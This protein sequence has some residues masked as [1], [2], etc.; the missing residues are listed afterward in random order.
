M[1]YK[2]SNYYQKYSLFCEEATRFKTYKKKKIKIKKEEDSNFYWKQSLGDKT[3][4]TI[5]GKPE[6]ITGRRMDSSHSS[7]R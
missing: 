1:L 7:P 3:Y 5:W 4:A 6:R 2:V